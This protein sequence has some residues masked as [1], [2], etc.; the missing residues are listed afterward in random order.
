L[1]SEATA[2]VAEP[3]GFRWTAAGLAV[4]LRQRPTPQIVAERARCEKLP[5]ELSISAGAPS[6]NLNDG[7]GCVPY[8]DGRTVNH[9]RSVYHFGARAR[10]RQISRCARHRR[11]ARANVA[12]TRS[13]LNRL[14][15]TPTVAD[16]ERAAQCFEQVTQN[17]DRPT[18]ISKYAYRS[19][20]LDSAHRR[21]SCQV[22]TGPAPH[23]RKAA[24]HRYH[25][26]S[27]NPLR[28]VAPRRSDGGR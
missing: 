27:R 24:A 2:S 26:R 21:S 10:P 20:G 17:R 22:P 18:A 28:G 11:R 3:R 6:I 7:G 19:N 13:S 15:A 12:R 8:R 14:I 1:A 23:V 5:S 16:F 4:D 25:R 9:R